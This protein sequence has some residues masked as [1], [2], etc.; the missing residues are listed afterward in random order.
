MSQ[1][2]PTD[3]SAPRYEDPEIQK[4]YEAGLRRIEMFSGKPSKKQLFKALWEIFKS[5]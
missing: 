4:V 5:V 2:S 1:K 3:S